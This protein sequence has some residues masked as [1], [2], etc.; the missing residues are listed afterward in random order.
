[1]QIVNDLTTSLHNRAC[2]FR[3]VHSAAQAA[4]LPELPE[5]H[6]LRQ[7]TATFILAHPDHRAVALLGDQFEIPPLE[8]GTQI[9]N[10]VGYCEWLKKPGSY[11]GD[12]EVRIL[13]ELLQV[14]ITVFSVRR[15]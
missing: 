1:M 13:A 5:Q 6:D 7:R 2:L 10:R 12:L 11:G 8:D 3:S 4:Q 9:L 15:H 14:D